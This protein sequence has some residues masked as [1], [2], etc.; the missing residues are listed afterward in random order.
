MPYLGILTL[1]VQIFLAVHAARTGRYWWVFII[2]IFPM[3]GSI[4]YLFAEYLPEMQN[5]SSYRKAGSLVTKAIDPGRKIREFQ[6]QLEITDSLKNRENLAEAYYQAGRFQEAIDLLEKS[7]QGQHR[8]DPFL[9]KGLCHSWF[10]LGNYE[11][12][13]YYLAQL[14]KAEEGKLSDPMRL[15]RARTHEGLNDFEAALE[16]YA[17]LSSSYPG[18][19]ARCRHALLLKKLG[20]LDEARDLFEQI[21]ANCRLSN[22]HYLKMQKSWLDIASGELKATA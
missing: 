22:R 16:E 13:R 14:A 7:L 18:E 4:I 11:N 2:I 17:A 20:K 1:I 3:I 12:A 6:R 15:L 10:A 9:L 5:N 21:K 8:N 19:E